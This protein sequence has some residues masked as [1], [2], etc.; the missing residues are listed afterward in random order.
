VLIFIHCIFDM[1]CFPAESEGIL[2]ISKFLMIFNCYSCQSNLLTL[3]LFCTLIKV[4]YVRFFYTQ[5]RNLVDSTRYFLHEKG[6][7]TFVDVFLG[8][9][10]LPFQ[11]SSVALWYTVI[12]QFITPHRN[13]YFSTLIFELQGSCSSFSTL[14]RKVD[15]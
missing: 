1:G 8:S 10:I 13:F 11:Q 4:I 15:F 3:F 7:N 9:P 6:F 14:M 5:A 2:T 12:A